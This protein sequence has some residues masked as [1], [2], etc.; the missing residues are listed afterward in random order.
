MR[1]GRWWSRARRGRSRLDAGIRSVAP[2]SGG[3]AGSSSRPRG[4]CGS[5]GLIGLRCS[6][7]NGAGCCGGLAL[8]ELTRTCGQ[9]ALFLLCRLCNVDKGNEVRI[10]TTGRR[11]MLARCVRWSRISRTTPFRL[12]AGPRRGA[13]RW[14]GRLWGCSDRAGFR[15]RTFASGH[16]AYP[17]LHAP[18]DGGGCL[19]Q[20]FETGDY[21][22]PFD[23]ID[24]AAP[25]AL[26]N[27]SLRTGRVEGRRVTGR[28]RWLIRRFRAGPQS[29]TRRHVSSP[30]SPNPAGRFPAPGSPVESCGSH[31]GL[32]G[33]ASGRVSRAVAPSSHPCAGRPVRRQTCSRP[34]DG[35]RTGR[36]LRLCM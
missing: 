21:G 20:W 28:V 5:F 7:P 29:E 3:I 17:L 18:A 15:V 25:E 26:E 16:D 4:R 36:P 9:E 1:C 6:S 23:G 34:D 10:A 8:R 14:L 13:G 24:A 11:G 35:D 27:V 2:G 30:R 33:A 32:P 31:T 12:P 19:A 22:S